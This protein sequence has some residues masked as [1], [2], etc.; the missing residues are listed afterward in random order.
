MGVKIAGPAG[1]SRAP[2]YRPNSSSS[3]TKTAKELG[4]T[5]PPVLLATADQVIE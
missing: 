3:S 1:A 2:D 4:L 5:L